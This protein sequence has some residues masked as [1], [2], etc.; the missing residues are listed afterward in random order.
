METK[1]R[2]DE[3]KVELENTSITYDKEEW[4]SKEAYLTSQGVVK[5]EEWKIDLINNY[6]VELDE[7]RC[8]D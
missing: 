7:L 6:G 5:L 3:I 4:G 2:E 1:K 8:K